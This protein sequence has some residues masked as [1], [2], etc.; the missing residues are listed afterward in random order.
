MGLNAGRRDVVAL[1]SRYAISAWPPRSARAWEAACRGRRPGRCR[2]RI[3]RRRGCGRCGSERPASGCSSA[4]RPRSGRRRCRCRCRSRNGSRSRRCPG[5]CGARRR[6]GRSCR[7]PGAVMQHDVPPGAVGLV[8]IDQFVGA[9]VI[10]KRLELVAQARPPNA[11]GVAGGGVFRT[12]GIA[13]PIRRRRQQS[14]WTLNFRAWRK[15]FGRRWWSRSIV[16]GRTGFIKAG[17]AESRPWPWDQPVSCAPA[18]TPIGL[19]LTSS[20]RV[21]TARMTEQK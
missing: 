7:S 21:W 17:L 12:I 18:P 19:G 10:E 5:S 4:G 15:R 6:S 9:R 1:C 8:G 3:R 16:P 20:N 13:T 2:F 11:V 14:R